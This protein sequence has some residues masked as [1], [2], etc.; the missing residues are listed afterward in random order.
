[1]AR[2]SK[3]NER[4][5]IISIRVPQS[6]AEEIR[7]I[8]QNIIYN[9]YGTD[10]LHYNKKKFLTIVEKLLRKKIKNEELTPNLILTLIAQLMIS[11]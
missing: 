11:I 9:T 5:R 3:F 1:M 6:K 8:L 10:A 2:P 4:S 7:P